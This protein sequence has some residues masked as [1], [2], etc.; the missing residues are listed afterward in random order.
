MS[1]RA[2]EGHA[3]GDPTHWCCFS[4][5]SNPLMRTAGPP[6]PLPPLRSPVLTGRRGFLN[7]CSYS[8]YDPEV[9]YCQGSPFI[10]GLLLMHMPEEDAF[11]T[12]IQMMRE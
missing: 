8:L 5:G 12:F 1:G 10:V 3:G 6:R 9:G 7:T 2:A 11:L 4:N